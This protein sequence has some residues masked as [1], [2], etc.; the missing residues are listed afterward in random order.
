[1]FGFRFLENFNYPYISKSVSE[2][3]RRWH[4]SLGRWFRDYVYFSL[5]GSRVGTKS[6]LIFNLFITWLLTG[7]WHGASWNFIVWGLMYFVLIT[8]E[9]ISGY[10]GKLN[11]T[12]GKSLY[13]VFT[14]LC[15]IFGWVVF[16][17]RGGSA[18]L[19]YI[20]SMLGLCGN[21]VFCDYVILAF[22]EYWFFLLCAVLFSTEF[23]AKTMSRLM[24]IESKTVYVTLRVSTFCLYIFCFLWAISFII[25]DAYNPFIYFNF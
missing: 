3:W 22:R 21:P 11:T 1:M 6:R 24:A 16:R 18:A 17:A 13:R 2:F 20:L 8:F 7:I 19:G 25:I 10:P 23:P 14:L 4:I 12:I 15:V 9:K 5:G